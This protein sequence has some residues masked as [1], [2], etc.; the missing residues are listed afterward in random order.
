MRLNVLTIFC[1]AQTIIKKTLK[2]IKN[3]ISDMA[4]CNRYLDR[5][6]KNPGAALRNTG[7]FS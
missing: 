2:K 1:A 6:K 7:I 4:N 3:Q 5:G